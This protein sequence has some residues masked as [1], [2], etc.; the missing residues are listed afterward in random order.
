MLPL[1]LTPIYYGKEKV[2]KAASLISKATALQVHRAFCL[3]LSYPKL[4]IICQ[5]CTSIEVSAL[6]CQEK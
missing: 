2:K 1:N 4:R 3:L 6:F 5:I